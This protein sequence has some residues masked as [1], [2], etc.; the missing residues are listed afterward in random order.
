MP[1][2]MV[3][4]A[5]AATEGALPAES[6][7]FDGS[8][9][10]FGAHMRRITGAVSFAE[11]VP[12][13]DQGD[14]LFVVHGHAREGLADV[15]A[16][17]DRVR[18][19]VRTFRVDVDQAHLHGS[20]GILEI[21]VARVTAHGLVAR[22]QPLGLGAPVDVF[23]RLP[24]V[25]AS[26]AEAEGLETHGLQCAV[27]SED[28]QVAPGDLPAVL[29]LDG[30]EQTARLVEVHVVG[31]AVERRKALAARTCAPAAV[32]HA[33]GA[34]TMPGHP[35]EEP[36][37]VTVVGRPPLL[38]VGHQRIEVLLHGPQVERLEFLGVVELF[39]HRIG[40]GRVLMKDPEV[41][42]VRPP[43]PVRRAG[44]RPPPCSSSPLPGTCSL[45]SSP[46]PFHS[47]EVWICSWHSLHKPRNW[48]VIDS[49]SP[50]SA[51]AS[52]TSNPS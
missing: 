36:P 26:A 18:V 4:P 52:E 19:A 13:G 46:L 29:L 9:L 38:R 20:E 10:R 31:P 21:P 30:P 48:T 50:R 51:A 43:V 37:V 40:Q 3:S 28:H 25:L 27:A 7:L 42:L 35:D 2:P 41:Q 6:L 16:G 17:G 47:L 23:L 11:R 1:L 34:R 15:T 44:R 22:G 39:A 12:A 8:R 14:G 24:D 49:T 32:P 5:F 33:V 45:R